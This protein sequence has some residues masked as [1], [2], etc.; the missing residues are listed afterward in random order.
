MKVPYK[1]QLLLAHFEEPTPTTASP[2]LLWKPP[3]APFKLFIISHHQKV[4]SFEII[5]RYCSLAF[6]SS[7]HLICQSRIISFKQYLEK[8]PPPGY[9]LLRYAWFHSALHQECY[10][11]VFPPSEKKQ[12][13]HVPEGGQCGPCFNKA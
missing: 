2:F 10:F 13:D 8:L 9:T 11:H 6:T 4:P 3:E 7:Q 1:N 5:Q 12:E